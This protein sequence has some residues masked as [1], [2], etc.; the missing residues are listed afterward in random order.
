MLKKNS[1]LFMEIQDY[2]YIEETTFESI[3]DINLT[4]KKDNTELLIMH[5]NIRSIK[6][7]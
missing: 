1:K 6:K 4:I 3:Q 2:N 5:F 7:M